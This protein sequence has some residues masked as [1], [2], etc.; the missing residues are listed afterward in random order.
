[1][2]KYIAFLLLL[3]SF[4]TIGQ[5]KIDEE[6]LIFIQKGTDSEFTQ[7]DINQ[8]VVDMEKY[9]IPAK[10]I[11]IETT[12]VPQEVGFTPFI[13]YRNYLG[14]KVYK[15]RYTSHQRILNFIRTV[16]NLPPADID[17]D[18]KNVLVWNHDQGKLILKLK[19]TELTGSVPANFNKKK[20]EQDYLKGL[21]KGFKGLSYV[22]KQHVT[23]S[24][25]MFYCNFYPY[26]ADDGK[27]YVSHE[28]F[29][30]YDCINPVYQQFG[31]PG[32]G[33]SFVEGFES[34]ATDNFKEI[35]RIIKESTLGDAMNFVSKNIK[36]IEW[37]DLNLRT[38]EAPQKNSS[39]NIKEVVFPKSWTMAGP[40]DDDTPMLSFNFP[41][42]LRQYGGELK[43]ITG[44]LSI[45]NN[46]S[47]ENAMAE[48]VVDVNFLEMGVSSLNDAV[49][50][51]MLFVDRFPTAK[52]EFKSISSKDFQLQLGKM[53]P[54]EIKADLT[55]VDK[56]GTISANA[57]FEPFLNDAGEL[58]LQ[59][60]TQFVAEDLTGTFHIEGPDGPAE[61]NNK[62]YFNATF[63]MKPA[64]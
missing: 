9:K 59:V 48:F 38:L 7:K 30:H 22:T 33:K 41:P 6:L 35:Q 23:T 2:S 16:R 31:K 18:E 63:L 29:S 52:L 3:L 55:I 11:D 13:M 57:Y 43:K 45:P 4:S 12:G 44:T 58:F 47:L 62:M 28:I 40:I 46:L 53:T 36:N 42:P 49:K 21:K 39:T 37:K 19:I 56:T 5:Q 64:K 34:A 10:I 51:S 25:E 61:A 60:T 26:L 24:D 32:V 54:A 8:L 15:G 14:N 50:K 27:V 20:F 17:Y 1:M